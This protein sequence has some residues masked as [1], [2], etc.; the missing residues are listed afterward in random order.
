[1]LEINL[2]KYQYALQICREKERAFVHLLRETE[3]KLG[4]LPPLS[5]GPERAAAEV[6]RLTES[7]SVSAEVLHS[8]TQA[9]EEIGETLQRA[10]RAAVQT[11]ETGQREPDIRMRTISL[12]YLKQYL[13]EVR[14]RDGG[15]SHE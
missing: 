7:L 11:W 13:A 9:L 12:E 4:A 1:M 10:E 5:E 2:P 6:R 15:G 3:D 8:F 14:F